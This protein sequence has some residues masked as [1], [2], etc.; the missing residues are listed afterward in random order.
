MK[1][2][3]KILAVIMVFALLV[4]GM[5]ISTV[6]VQ[7]AEKVV[8]N[9]DFKT[10]EDDVVKDSSGNGNDGTIGSGVTVADGVATFA[11]GNKGIELPDDIFEDAETITIEI[12][13]S[14]KAFTKYMSLFCVGDSGGEWVVI[15]LMDDGSVRYAVATNGDDNSQSK[16]NSTS[17]SENN[18]HA[19]FRSEE[20]LMRDADY[21]V[22]YVIEQ[23]ETNV[24]IDG[25]LALTVDTEGKDL[26]GE[27]GGPVVLG[28]A[29]K[30]PDPSFQGT[31]SSLKI[32]VEGNFAVAEPTD[33]PSTT[34]GTEATPEATE[35]ATAT[36]EA[37]E[38]ATATPEA[39]TAK[40]S[41]TT[42]PTA[43][44]TPVDDAP[45]DG[46]FPIWIIIVIAAVVV[47]VVVVVIIVAKK[48]KA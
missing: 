9:W 40:P 8:L 4:T 27:L 3:S 5:M 7:A 25:E 48:K 12:A 20:T 15:G 43:T 16:A 44:T 39:T 42:A 33:E 47:A 10:V 34:E 22:K 35:E 45:V 14:P 26:I 23:E 32:T 11:D 18:E 37:T 13:L 6:S 31:I 30:W 38:E 2:T 41:A 17:A 21:V 29:T 28:A 19:S 46:G 24:Y 1:R 36:P